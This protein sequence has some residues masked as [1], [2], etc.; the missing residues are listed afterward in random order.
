MRMIAIHLKQK[1][2]YW[3]L[4]MI[5]LAPAVWADQ[6]KPYA[7]AGAGFI[8]Y[9]ADSIDNT[10]LD[11]RFSNYLARRHFNLNFRPIHQS[12][13]TLTGWNFKQRLFF[14]GSEKMS[15]MRQSTPGL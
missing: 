12:P 2:Y 3:F 4:G 1:F 8:F 5:S 14:K 13:T 9:T 15:M 7:T 11:M 10:K 6:D